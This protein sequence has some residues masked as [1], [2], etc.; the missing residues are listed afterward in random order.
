MHS[1]DEKK[2]QQQQKQ[3]EM[4]IHAHTLLQINDKIEY[5]ETIDY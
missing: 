3:F 4:M 1:H 2:Q 5:N